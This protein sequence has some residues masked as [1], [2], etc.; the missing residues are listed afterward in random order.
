M[1]C[2]RCKAQNTELTGIDFGGRHAG[3]KVPTTRL[4]PDHARLRAACFPGSSLNAVPAT[5]RSISDATL[6]SPRTLLGT[7]STQLKHQTRLLQSQATCNPVSIL[8]SMS[9]R[10][11]DQE[12][13][14]QHGDRFRMRILSHCSLRA[15][16]RTLHPLPEMVDDVPEKE[17]VPMSVKTQSL[18][19][20]K[21][22]DC[23]GTEWCHPATPSRC[24][25]RQRGQR[26]SCKW[27]LFMS[28]CSLTYEPLQLLR[29][30]YL[31][32]S[33][34]QHIRL[35]PSRTAASAFAAA[36]PRAA[37]RTR[38]I[39]PGCPR[40]ARCGPQA[41]CRACRSRRGHPAPECR[42][43]FARTLC[44]GVLD[45]PG[46]PRMSRSGSQ[47]RQAR[48]TRLQPAARGC[49]RRGARAGIHGQS[50]Q[51]RPG[52]PLRCQSR[53]RRRPGGCRLGKRLGL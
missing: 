32:R 11:S 13:R 40:S 19:L 36:A 47:Y 16:L 42:L 34:A 37:V 22:T 4:F 44:A 52:R 29:E 24:I 1:S 46:C 28:D 23:F 41:P 49:A 30:T 12:A 45:R 9:F 48:C 6:C 7:A 51:T 5:W 20:R 25:A 21:C 39:P 43:R 17:H 18:S 53:A 26:E 15:S 3:H 27:L 2:K 38:E 10:S 14:P 31:R 8:N 35:S 50:R 33:P